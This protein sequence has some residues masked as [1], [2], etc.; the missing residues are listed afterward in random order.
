MSIIRAKVIHMTATPEPNKQAII[1]EGA[2]V[3][4]L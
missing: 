1:D 4:S 2:M 3:I